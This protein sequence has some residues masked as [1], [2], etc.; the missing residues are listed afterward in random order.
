MLFDI[1]NIQ[2]RDEGYLNRVHGAT[3]TWDYLISPSPYA[4]KAFRSAFK[5][6]GKYWKRDIREMICFTR[7]M[8]QW[9]P[10]Q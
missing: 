8:L 7:K 1:D 9:L 2:G 6:E 3:R 4:S 5:Y 10:T